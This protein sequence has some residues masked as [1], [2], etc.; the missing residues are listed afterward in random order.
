[1]S[2]DCLKRGR[3]IALFLHCLQA[4][5]PLEDR[6]SSRLLD[7]LRDAMTIT[8]KNGMPLCLLTTNVNK[9]GRPD[10][11][12]MRFGDGIYKLLRSEDVEVAGCAPHALLKT[13]DGL[14]VGGGGASASQRKIDSHVA[15]DTQLTTNQEP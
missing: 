12:G 7:T 15:A 11:A 2:H 1:M 9:N 4:C 3:D 10:T 13:L 8:Q 6:I 5:Y 14:R